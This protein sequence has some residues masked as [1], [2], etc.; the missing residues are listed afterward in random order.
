MGS[1]F[2]DIMS[3]KKLVKHPIH[4]RKTLT[5]FL[6]QR[7]F[8]VLRVVEPRLCPLEPGRLTAT[9]IHFKVSRHCVGQS[10]VK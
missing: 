4:K 8:C 3:F 6:D 1:V 10:S 9:I 5:D 7:R 2:I